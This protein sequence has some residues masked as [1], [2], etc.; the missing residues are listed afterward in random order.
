MTGDLE[1]RVRAIEEFLGL[2]DDGRE[3][4]NLLR[5]T[6]TEYHVLRVLRRNKLVSHGMAYNALYA[7]RP[8]CDQ[9]GSNIV[10]M[11]ISRLRT[12]LRHY[13]IEIGTAQGRGHYLTSENKAKLD[14]ILGPLRDQQAAE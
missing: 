1:A 3:I 10:S 5:L 13:K 4:E 8:E 2:V 7:G 9:P 14:A 6:Q 11:Y 12:K